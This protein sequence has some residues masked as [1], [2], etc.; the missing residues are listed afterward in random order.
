MKALVL[1]VGNHGDVLPFVALAA[2]LKNHG[3]Q[4]SLGVPFK[5]ADTAKRY[6]IRCI[7]LGVDIDQLIKSRSKKQSEKRNAAL[8][9]FDSYRTSAALFA[10]FHD[11]ISCGLRSDTLEEF[12]VVAY[13]YP[14]ICGDEIA[15]RFDAVNAPVCLQP[16]R[17]PTRS[18]AEPYFPISLPRILNPVSYKHKKFK[19]ACSKAYSSTFRS[20]KLGLK[21]RRGIYDQLKSTN[22]RKL[23]ILQAF[24]KHVF[25]DPPDYP[26]DV[27]T[28]NFWFPSYGSDWNPPRELVDFLASGSTPVCVGFG[29]SVGANPDTTAQIVAEAAHLADVRAILVP[30]GGGIA[31]REFGNEIFCSE[32]IPFGWL[33]SRVSAVV[34][35]GGIGTCSR[36]LAAGIPQVICP[37]GV[38]HEFF[39]KRMVS[40]GVAADPQPQNQLNARGLAD[41]IIH[42][43]TSEIMSNSASRMRH[44]VT[45]SDGP[46]EAVKILEE[47][48]GK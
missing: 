4:V 9:Y 36:A 3:H 16:F 5:F 11:S 27:Y 1:T 41:A 43:T 26:D 18:F 48:I 33:F 46:L 32:E 25:P 10:H 42:A 40:L 13:H 6:G 38:E 22:D 17:I 44:L 15:E 20:E 29:S 31:K 19:M 35:H 28:T 23:V 21:H 14:L 37:F 12:D 8:R 7:P 39:A 2:A 30:G 34:H 45:D 24:N 47:A